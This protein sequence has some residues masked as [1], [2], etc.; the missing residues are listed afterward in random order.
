MNKLAAFEQCYF[1][2]EIGLD[3]ILSIKPRANFRIKKLLRKT[4]W[5]PK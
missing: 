5:Y 3:S 1:S 2:N 4:K